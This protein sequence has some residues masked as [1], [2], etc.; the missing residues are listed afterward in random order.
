[1]KKSPFREGKKLLTDFYE[2]QSR[3]WKKSLFLFI[4]LILFYYV[5]IVFIG[6]AILASLGF[7]FTKVNIFTTAGIV[8]FLWVTGV[9]AFLIAALHFY[10]AK[11]FGA[12][13]ILDRMQAKPPEPEDRYHKQFINSVD[14]IRIAAGLPKIE[15]YIIP[16]FAVNSMALIKPDNTP[17]ILVTEGLLADFTRD[18][19]Q[20]VIAH[21][22]AHVVRGDTYYITLVCSLANFFERTKQALEPD[23]STDGESF[24]ATKEGRGGHA[25]LYLAF[26]FSSLVMH[27]LSTLISRQREILADAAAVEFTRNP[28]SLARAVYKAHLKNS[29]VGDFQLT[30]SPLFIVPPE[31]KGLESES[32]WAN[33][34]T[35]HPPLNKRLKLLADMIPSTPE[36]VVEEVWEIQ[37]HRENARELVYSSE[38]QIQNRAG[39][40]PTPEEILL[41]ANKIWALCGPQGQW[42]G[43]FTVEELLVLPY[44]SPDRMLRNLQEKVEAPAREFLQVH[45]ARHKFLK[46]KPL[47]PSQYN[48]CPSCQIPL[49]EIFYEGVTVKEC[50][51]CRGKLVPIP[52]MG[53]IISRKEKSF[54]PNIKEKAEQFR[55]ECMLN[56]AFT[57]KVFQRNLRTIFCPDC[58]QRMLLRPYSYH[59]VVPVDK[60]FNCGKI[61]FDPDEMEILQVLIED[62]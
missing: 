13:F 3:Q 17:C 61:W 49:R 32:F 43:P 23:H 62:R 21:E 37:N 6:F 41:Q 1:M 19:L 20:A 26:V 14:E 10:D 38:E 5:L 9:V 27:L 35:S 44:F 2:A 50:P 8:K 47:R 45:R 24:P 54:S 48:K 46:L 40:S 56:P 34:F 53:R 15:P 55:I 28:R 25:L 52:M 51:S 39:S 18:E 59:Y 7:V 30:Y 16:F 29:F 36:K 60:C 42:E 57:R 11:K 12:K 4:V 31:S 58:G 33:V 22:L